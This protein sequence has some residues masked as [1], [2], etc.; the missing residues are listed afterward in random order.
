MCLVFEVWTK[1]AS[2]AKSTVS[3]RRA[4]DWAVNSFPQLTKGT[5]HK[6]K[7]EAKRWR[8]KSPLMLN[9]FF[10]SNFSFSFS[11]LITVYQKY[12]K[13]PLIFFCFFFF[14]IFPKRIRSVFSERIY[15]LYSAVIN[16][17]FFWLFI[18]VHTV[19][20]YL[21]LHLQRHGNTE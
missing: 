18:T 3:T 16:L 13:N 15:F 20:I 17:F 9:R 5:T 19:L 2:Y 8:K 7:L 14:C 4:A 11:L 6:K 21:Y 10:F 1:H 12:N